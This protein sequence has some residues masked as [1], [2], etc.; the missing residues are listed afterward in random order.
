MAD[1]QELQHATLKTLKVRDE[2]KSLA[3]FTDLTEEE[4]FLEEE[5][6]EKM[7]SEDQLIQLNDPNSAIDIN[8]MV[9]GKKSYQPKQD[10]TKPEKSIRLM[11]SKGLI[12][13]QNTALM[14]IKQMEYSDSIFR[15]L[16]EIIQ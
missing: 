15:V 12:K 4:K 2:V 9:K 6:K 5:T 8:L 11:Q 10:I 1:N 3:G 14:T 13:K 16:I 7:R